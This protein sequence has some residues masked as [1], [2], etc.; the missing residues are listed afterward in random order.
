MDLR[1]FGI[2][3]LTHKEDL[4]PNTA[5]INNLRDHG[6]PFVIVKRYVRADDSICW[7]RNH[8]SRISNGVGGM[9]YLATVEAVDAPLD[10][11]RALLDL[12]TR[13]LKWRDVRCGRFGAEIFSE[14]ASDM[15][16][17]L[18]VSEQKGREVCVSSACLASHVPPTT[19][20]RHLSLLEEKGLIARVPDPFD[21][22]RTVVELTGQGRATVTAML[23]TFQRSEGR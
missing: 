1:K 13:V 9:V 6:E 4:A 22:R 10:G 14:P 11:D 20:L 8:V 12:A 16:V 19:A 23:Q 3:E 2:L 15:L 7:V 5:H 18:F 17:D 21:R